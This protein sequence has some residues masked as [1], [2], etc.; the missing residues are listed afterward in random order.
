[1]RAIRIHGYG[2]ASVLRHEDVPRPVP[3][4]GEVLIRVA[5]TSFNPSEIGLRSG[6]LRSV[7]PLELPHVLGWDVAGTV[8]EVGSNVRTFTIHDRVIGLLDSGAAAEYAVAPIETLVPAPT[9]IPLTY[10]A[11]I[12]VAGL[13]AWQAVFDHAHVTTGQR[14]LVNGA[15]GGVGGFAVQLAKYAGAHVIATASPRSSGAV[16]RLGADEII[17]YTASPIADQLDEPV[18]TV[19]NLAAITRRQADALAPLL[20]PGGILVSITTP[21]ELPTGIPVTVK[22]FVARN[23]TSQLAELVALVDTGAVHID[24]A[25]YRP[26]ADLAAVHRDAES[27]RTRGKIIVVP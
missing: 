19:L 17:D 9:S 15:G 21:I 27:G 26:L 25:A 2:D 16:G 11:A 4:R 13:T 22:N 10:S 24:V 14:V 1:M 7:F 6:L 20:R 12:P 3:E 5:A 23:D 18:D 8:V